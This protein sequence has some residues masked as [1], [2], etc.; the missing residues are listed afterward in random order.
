L[1]HYDLEPEPAADEPGYRFDAHV[2]RPGEYVSIAEA[3]GVT[4]TFRVTAVR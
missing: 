1:F 2:F 4:R 3:D